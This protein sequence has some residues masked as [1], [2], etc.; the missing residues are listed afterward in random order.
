MSRSTDAGEVLLEVVERFEESGVEFMVVGAFAAMAHG[1][2]RTT[3]DIDLAVHMRFSER[4]SLRPLVAS[5]GSNVEKRS[6]PEWGKRLVSTHP[7]GLE[8]EVFFAAGHQL[9]EREFERKVRGRF[10]SHEIPFISPEDLILRKLVNTRLRRGHDWQD[11]LAVAQVQGEE[12]DLDYL[13][14]HCAPHRV[15]GMVEELAEAIEA[16][17]D[18]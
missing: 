5:L 6:D 15:C 10:R 18:D 8:I 14:K 3:A 17:K 1:H 7:S 2:P 16:S 12:L 13:R 9:Y 11:A 4:E